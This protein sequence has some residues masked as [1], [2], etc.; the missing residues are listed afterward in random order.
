MSP[1]YR[2]LATL[3]EQHARCTSEHAN[4]SQRAHAPAVRSRI[5]GLVGNHMP[6]GGGVDCGTVLD[7]DASRPNRLV[8]CVQFHHM[9]IFGVYAGWTSHD[10]VLTPDLASGFNLRITG[11]NRNDVKDDLADLFHH[12]LSAEYP[13]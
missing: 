7:L 6:S 4:E 2:I 8:F 9:N 12:C 10:V 11:P 3:V 13:S 5:A 1:L